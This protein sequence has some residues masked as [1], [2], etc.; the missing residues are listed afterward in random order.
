[1]IT[2]EDLKG[3]LGKRCV[4]TFRDGHVFKGRLI[5]WETRK[6][7]LFLLFEDEGWIDGGV[8]SE[9]KAVEEV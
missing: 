6:E 9:I 5:G 2:F 1:M 8:V 4:V 7:G 3:K